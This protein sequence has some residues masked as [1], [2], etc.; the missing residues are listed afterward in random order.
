MTARD[1]QDIWDA[2]C[3]AV[4]EIKPADGDAF[5]VGPLTALGCVEQPSLIPGDTVW[6]ITAENPGGRDHEP[7]DNAIYTQQLRAELRLRGLSALTARGGDL[8]WRHT[9]DSFAVIGLDENEA[10]DLG[11]RFG[12]DAIF[13][14]DPDYWHVVS[15]LEERRIA[16]PWGCIRS[17]GSALQQRRNPQHA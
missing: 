17:T 3:A 15:C 16:S 10:L 14:W 7:R 11:R 5:V 1:E 13:A 9:E 2:Y 4:V 12:Q 6:I 8:S